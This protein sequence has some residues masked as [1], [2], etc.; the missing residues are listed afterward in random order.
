MTIANFPGLGA[1]VGYSDRAIAAEPSGSALS[2]SLSL[3][4]SGRRRPLPSDRGLAAPVPPVPVS[5]LLSLLAAAAGSLD[6][7]CVAQLGGPFASVIT[8]NLVQ[9]GRGVTAPDTALAVNAAVAVAAYAVGVALATMVLRGRPVGWY[10]PASVLASAEVVALAAILAGWL[11]TSGEPPAVTTGVLLGLAGSAMGAQSVLTLST[12]RRRASTTY[13][14]GT[15]TAVVQGAIEPVRHRP[16][17]GG[18]LR[19]GTL[20]LG[21]LAGGLLLRFAP[22]WTPVLPL[23]LVTAVVILAVVLGRSRP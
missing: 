2:P 8:G 9:I 19:L 4:L 6:V 7:F 3:S 1:R 16:D 14:T 10:R 20:L 5:W 23:A 12:G 13:L 18:L 21:A 15:L 22:L 11:G 17:R